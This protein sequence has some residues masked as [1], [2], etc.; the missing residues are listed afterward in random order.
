MEVRHFLK[1]T[2][3]RTLV[4]HDSRFIQRPVMAYMGRIDEHLNLRLLEKL[5]AETLNRNVL[6]VGPVS[7]ISPE[8]LPR[9]QNIFWLGSRPYERLPNYLRG[10]DAC[11]LPMDRLLD[12]DGYMPSQIYEIL[13][14][15]RPLVVSPLRE[16]ADQKLAGV[17]VASSETDFIRACHQAVVPMTAATRREIIRQVLGRSWT[18]VSEAVRNLLEN[19]VHAKRI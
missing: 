13:C 8:S 14:A 11:I 18:R 6:M 7:G 3:I 12:L 1:A 4:P 16:L 15:G 9:P 19:V 17:H 5:A 10:V 2:R